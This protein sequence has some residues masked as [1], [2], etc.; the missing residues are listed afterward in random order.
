[1]RQGTQGRYRY[2]HTDSSIVT[3]PVLVGM[4][5]ERPL[6]TILLLAVLII[7][8]GCQSTNAPAGVEFSTDRAQ[9]APGDDVQLRLVNGVD[10]TLGYNLC[11]SDLERQD[12]QEWQVVPDPET[13]CTTVQH[14]LSPGDSAYFT[15][16]IMTGIPSGTYRYRTNV[17]HREDERQDE[18]ATDAFRVEE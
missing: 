8:L 17:E 15:K 10:Q 6:G 2:R 9:Y 4:P 3:F 12:G 16:T 7:P 13:V 1:M 14:G 5:M 11:F 18:L